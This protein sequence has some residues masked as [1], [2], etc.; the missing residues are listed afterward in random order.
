MGPRVFRIPLTR[1][2]QSISSPFSG[3]PLSGAIWT[4]RPRWI[5]LFDDPAA[6][7]DRP[8]ES[9]I[10]IMTVHKAKGLEF[11]TVVLL[12]LGRVPQSD[13][14]RALYWHE[15]VH[16]DG[17]ESV[18]LAP[19]SAGADEPDP[20]TRW[21]KG[22][23][24]RKEYSERARLLY[25]ATTRARERLHLIGQLPEGK[26]TPPASSLLAFLWP[27]VCTAFESATSGRRLPDQSVRGR[28][29]AETQTPCPLPR[30]A[31]RQRSYRPGRGRATAPISNGRGRLRCKSGSWFTNGCIQLQGRGSSIGMPE[32]VRAG[33]DRYGAELQL[34]GVDQR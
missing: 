2:A 11:D 5:A 19:F 25:V 20:H 4:I 9:G 30:A 1:I 14:G 10:E 34:L 27:Q 21:L 32:R 12:G 28:V 31:T 24:Q 7:V 3:R 26:T 13:K 16:A 6:I 17:R 15:R 8:R 23:E 18:L 33:M 29:R 22:I